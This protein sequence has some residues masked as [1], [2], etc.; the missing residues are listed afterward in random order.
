M[1]TSCPIDMSNIAWA[2]FSRRRLLGCVLVITNY[3][4]TKKMK[5]TRRL[6][7]KYPNDVRHVVWA[8]FCHRQ[9]LRRVLTL[10]SLDTRYN[11]KT[12][13]SV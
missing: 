1:L 11:Q 9:L 3:S 8:H 4:N 10:E 7:T 5:K 13:V 6:L 2:L 12:L